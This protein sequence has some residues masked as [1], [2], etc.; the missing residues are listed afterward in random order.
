MRCVLVVAVAVALGGLGCGSRQESSASTS[1]G[2][3]A[4]VAPAPA[5]TSLPPVPLKGLAA[6]NHQ[7]MESIRKSLNSYMLDNDAYP[8]TNSWDEAIQMMSVGYMRSPIKKDG[9]AHP[10]LYRSDG[11]G[12]VLTSPGNDGDPG[13]ADDIV[14]VDGQYHEAI[15]APRR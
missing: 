7:L 6:D 14:L 1:P 3:G 15:L 11:H 13:T 12:Y 8:K 4:R 10:F 5:A 9:W 2:S